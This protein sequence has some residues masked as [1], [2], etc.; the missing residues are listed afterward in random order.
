VTADIQV[1]NKALNK[2]FNPNGF[3]LVNVDTATIAGIFFRVR[4]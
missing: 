2:T 1:I 3:G 4:F